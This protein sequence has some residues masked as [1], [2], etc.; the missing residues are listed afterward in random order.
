MS[1]TGSASNELRRHMAGVAP[2]RAAVP[3]QSSAS[4]VLGQAREAPLMA[5]LIAGSIGYGLGWLTALSRPDRH[6]PLPDYAR[7]RA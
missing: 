5:I 1:V 4:A 2:S 3:A 7:K 6:E